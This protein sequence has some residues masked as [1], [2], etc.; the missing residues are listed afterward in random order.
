MSARDFFAPRPWR[1]AALALGLAAAAFASCKAAGGGGGGGDEASAPGPELSC[2]EPR[3]YFVDKVWKPLLSQQCVGCHTSEGQA[4]NTR[5]VLT[6]SDEPAALDANFEATKALALAT[7]AAGGESLLT[8]KPTGRARGGHTGG[9]LVGE[10]GPLYGQLETFAKLVRGERVSCVDESTCPPDAPG[11][12][13]LRRLSRWEYDRTVGDLFG[14]ASSRASSFVDDALAN[15]FD[16][17]A[18]VTLVAGA[19]AAQLSAAADEIAEEVGAPAK[20]AAL[21]PCAAAAKGE[22]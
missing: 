1:R 16:N 9:A 17:N 14:I 7:E 18:R 21:L 12:R 15:G 20:L 6:P 2:G 3:A 5:L 10:G 4:R 19:L 22:D 11:P 8:L 13:A